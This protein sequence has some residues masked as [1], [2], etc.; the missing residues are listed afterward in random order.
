MQALSRSVFAPGST[1]MGRQLPISIAGA[2]RAFASQAVLRR[3]AARRSPTLGSMPGAWR[4]YR[5]AFRGPSRHQ[6]R[7]CGTFGAGRAGLARR[8]SREASASSP[9]SQRVRADRGDTEPGFPQVHPGPR[10]AG[11][12]LRHRNGAS[13]PR[14]GRQKRAGRRAL[15]APRAAPKHFAS[16]SD[17][18]HSP[19]AQ[20]LLRLDG[21]EG[22]FLANEFLTVT[23]NS[24]MAWEVRPAHCGLPSR[25]SAPLT[26]VCPA[27]DVK[28]DVFASLMD[29]FT[30]GQPIVSEHDQAASVRRRAR[31]PADGWAGIASPARRLRQTRV[32]RSRVCSPTRQAPPAHPLRCSPNRTLRFWT[33]TTR[34]SRSS[35]YA[36]GTDSAG[37]GVA[38]HSRSPP[39]LP[40]SRS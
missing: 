23:K 22:V 33:T 24:E 12:P 37:K 16:L 11:V 14:E 38:C 27:Q 6:Q 8:S 35:R 13:R 3:M 36:A 39:P 1:R 17:A 25:R 20:Q 31:L 34:W 32:K 28:P 9:S 7:C 19:L 26:L 2:G 18:Q 4:R 29:F 10:S 40:A 30:S 5:L 15:T 21:V